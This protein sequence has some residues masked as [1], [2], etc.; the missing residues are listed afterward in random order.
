MKIG[1]LTSGHWEF[2][3]VQN[4][5]FTVCSWLHERKGNLCHR[6]YRFPHSRTGQL[7]EVQNL[8]NF[9]A[10][11]DV[12]LGACHQ[13]EN[14]EPMLLKEFKNPLR[15]KMLKVCLLLL[16]SSLYVDAE[17]LSAQ[18][19]FIEPNIT[20]CLPSHFWIRF[21]LCWS[22]TQSVYLLKNENSF[23]VI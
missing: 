20:V 18:P 12:S 7:P 1:I 11:T 22:S 19:W 4:T 16:S 3:F 9:T 13:Y 21:S 14:L 23:S 8:M 2:H 5:V 17:A 6:T 15:F 10:K